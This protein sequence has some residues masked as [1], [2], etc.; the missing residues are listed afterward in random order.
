MKKRIFELLGVTVIAAVVFVACQTTEGADTTVK[1]VY[2]SEI[3]EVISDGETD[4]GLT[5][6]KETE[7]AI[8]I[9]EEAAQVYVHVC[10][11]VMKP[12]VYAVPDGS[13]LYEATALAGGML[14]TADKDS[15]NLAR[16]VRDGEQVRIPFEGEDAQE[17]GLIDVNR[18]DE[19]G[20]CQI[21]GVGESK[22]R[23]IVAYREANGPFESV[24]GLT[25]VTGIK[26][27]LLEQIRP[28]I[29]CE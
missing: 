18:A 22:A 14:D 12:G 2:H 19:K 21:P 20:L 17:D 3:G 9:N 13:R 24:E 6:L 7:D 28:Y 5:I 25:Q 26:E 29:K 15:I 23:A 4:G 27:G 11:A 16:E 10:G 8:L 1:T